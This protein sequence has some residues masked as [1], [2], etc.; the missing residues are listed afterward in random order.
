MGGGVL[1]IMVFSA[2]IPSTGTITRRPRKAAW[3]AVLG[4]AL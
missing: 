1:L 4:T 2:D 3:L